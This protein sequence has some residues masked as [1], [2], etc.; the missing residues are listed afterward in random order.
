MLLSDEKNAPI[1][2]FEKN[3]KE[4]DHQKEF[5]TLSKEGSQTLTEEEK[6][7]RDVE[8]WKQIK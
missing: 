5:D 6:T 1:E 8:L 4:E 2:E 3:F 7:K